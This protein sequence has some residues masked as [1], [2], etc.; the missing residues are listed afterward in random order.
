MAKRR[1]KQTKAA[2]AARSK[3]RRSKRRKKGTGSG[4]FSK[5]IFGDNVVTR[6][7]PF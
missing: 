5:M 6:M 4:F 7:L 1:L 3:Y 2:R